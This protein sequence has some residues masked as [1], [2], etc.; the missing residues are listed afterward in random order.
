MIKFE[1]LKRDWIRSNSS[2]S[3]YVWKARGRPPNSCQFCKLQDTYFY[4][5]TSILKISYSPRSQSVIL[6]DAALYVRRN[7]NSDFWGQNTHFSPVIK[8]NS[9][10]KLRYVPLTLFLR[11][12]KYIN[13]YTLLRIFFFSHHLD[14]WQS[15]IW[16]RQAR[17]LGSLQILGL[18]FY[19]LNS[20]GE[21][22]K[23]RKFFNHSPKRDYRKK[24]SNNCSSSW[25]QQGYSQLHG[26]N[27]DYKTK[28]VGSDEPQ[29]PVGH[30]LSA[31]SDFFYQ[32]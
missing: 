22:R 29:K 30:Y 5:T 2:S 12:W 7:K 24:I 21:I 20:L 4:S 19:N 14:A 17:R 23:L 13:T 9:H 6:V 28:T 26:N 32:L 11:N 1:N 8:F 15:L 31:T 27:A 18:V 16:Y 25:S 3:K 10:Y